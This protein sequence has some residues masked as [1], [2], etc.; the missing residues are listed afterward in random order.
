MTHTF[1][2][3]IR[4]YVSYVIIVL[5]ILIQKNFSGS[6]TDGLFTTAVSNSSLSPWEKSLG[7][8]FGIIQCGFR[9]CIKKKQY[10]VC[11]H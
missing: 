1:C 7:F 9:F 3:F 10:I 6:N 11:T 4:T 5:E 8:R 2:V